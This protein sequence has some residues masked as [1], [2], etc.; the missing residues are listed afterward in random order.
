MAIPILAH[1]I[2]GLKVEM[3][4]RFGVHIVDALA[5]LPHKQHAVVF[6]QRKVISDDPLEEFTTSYAMCV[7]ENQESN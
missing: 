6:G 7:R 3:D 1:D 4:H 2:L 5:D